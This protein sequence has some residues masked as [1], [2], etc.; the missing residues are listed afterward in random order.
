[1]Q[2][3]RHGFAVIDDVVHRDGHRG[4]VTLQHHAQRIADQHEVRVGVV[5]QAPRSSRR[6]QVMH[7][8]FSPSRFMRSSVPSVT[9][10]RVESRCSRCVYI[11]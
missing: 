7:A 5:A 4:V 10:G 9:G 11:G 8:I 6:R 1:M 2:S 3:A